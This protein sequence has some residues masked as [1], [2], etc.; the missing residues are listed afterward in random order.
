MGTGHQPC[1]HAVMDVTRI[2]RWLWAIRVYKTRSQ[3]SAACRAGHVRVNGAVAKPG[4]QVRAGD[5]VAARLHDRERLLEVVL[6]IDARVGPSVAA[7][8]V[9]DHSPPPPPRETAP[10][11]FARDLGVGRPTKRDRRQLDRLRGH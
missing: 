11:A 4:A 3:A 9:V 1:H 6:V 10:P 5:R 2:D 8:C 7:D